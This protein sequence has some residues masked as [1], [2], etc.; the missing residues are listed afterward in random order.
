VEGSDVLEG[1]EDVAVQLDVRDAF[2]AAIRGQ[3]A[4]LIFAAEELDFDLFPFV[5]VRVVLHRW[6]RSGTTF[7]TRLTVCRCRNRFVRT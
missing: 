6:E 7:T 2:D 4:V 3:R 5:F 1:D